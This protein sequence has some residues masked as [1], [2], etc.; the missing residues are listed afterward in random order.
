MPMI[1]TSGSATV[2]CDRGDG[3]TVSAYLLGCAL[4]TVRPG[5]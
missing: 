2:P 5:R 1:A 3:G 4:G